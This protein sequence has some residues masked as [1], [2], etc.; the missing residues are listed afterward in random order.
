MTDLPD[1]P[2]QGDDPQINAD[3]NI[4]FAQNAEPSVWFWTRSSGTSVEITALRGAP[5]GGGYATKINR[6][7]NIAFLAGDTREIWLYDATAMA[8][9]S[10]ATLPAFQDRRKISNHLAH[11][12]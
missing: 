6:T 11:L 8:F 9:T 10:L 5:A 12:I 3:G 4:A 1:G 2:G 7:N